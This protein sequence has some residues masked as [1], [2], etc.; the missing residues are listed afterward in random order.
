MKTNEENGRFAGPGELRIVRNL[1]GP[2]ERVWEYLTD[3]DKRGRWFAG[4]P[5][6]PRKGG[7]I[8]LRFRHKDLAPQETPPAGYEKYH[9][10]GASME[11][12]VTR[13]EPPHVLAYT[14]G[15]PDSEVT[16]ELTEQGENVRLVLIHRAKGEDLDYMADF[17]AGWHTHVSHLL[18]LLEGAKAPPFWPEHTRLKAVYA[19]IRAGAGK[20]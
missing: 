9:D 12:V 6:E 10:P 11:G 16:F 20:A 8:T 4:G 18:A 17:G 1:P 14:F 19:K 15:G 2:I 5:M 7:K 3:A 13:F